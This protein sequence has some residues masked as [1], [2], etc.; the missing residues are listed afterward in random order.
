MF[1]VQCLVYNCNIQG[2]SQVPVVRAACVYNYIRTQSS[3]RLCPSMTEKWW[4]PNQQ[5][6]AVLLQ[7]LRLI[8]HRLKVAL[9]KATYELHRIGNNLEF[10]ATCRFNIWTRT[11]V[12]ADVRCVTSRCFVCRFFKQKIKCCSGNMSYCDCE[13]TLNS[14]ALVDLS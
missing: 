5:F 3:S 13:K 10:L 4:R 14:S 9:L 11:F 1:D 8:A 12:E 7:N 6:Q 2:N